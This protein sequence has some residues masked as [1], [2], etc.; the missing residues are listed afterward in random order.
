MLK[1]PAKSGNL[2]EGPAKSGNLGEGPL[3]IPKPILHNI[4]QY[5]LL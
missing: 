2:G 3:K 1:G 4:I 5:S